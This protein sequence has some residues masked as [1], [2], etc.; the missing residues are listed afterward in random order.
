MRA[1]ADSADSRGIHLQPNI[2]YI[3][4]EV[5]LIGLFRNIFA[6]TYMS[7]LSHRHRVAGAHGRTEYYSTTHA[8]SCTAA[9]LCLPKRCDAVI[10]GSAP[11]LRPAA[12]RPAA[13]RS[14]KSSA[15]LATSAA[16]KAGL[17]SAHRAADQPQAL[18]HQHPQIQLLHD[19][20]CRC[21]KFN[22]P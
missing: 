7:T 22:F 1:C 14:L 13:A 10:V 4:A 20:A 12:A 15:N 9:T 18:P 5:Y 6:A 8:S 17:R 11:Y 19:R 2:D 16:L 3:S 21:Y